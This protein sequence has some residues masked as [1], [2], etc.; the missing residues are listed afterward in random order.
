ME[1]AG[2]K[3]GDFW[4]ESVGNALV[5]CFLGGCIFFFNI[6]ILNYKI[7]ND[8]LGFFTL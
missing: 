6:I 1:S 2:K 8:K 4:G 7:S 3:F 5:A